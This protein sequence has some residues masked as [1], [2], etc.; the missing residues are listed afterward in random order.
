MYWKELTYGFKKYCTYLIITIFVA[1]FLNKF[2]VI[3]IDTQKDS[4]NVITINSDKEANEFMKNFLT[5]VKISHVSSIDTG[6]ADINGKTKAD[7][8]VYYIK[9]TLQVII[10]PTSTKSQ[11][12]DFIFSQFKT[13]TDYSLNL[14]DENRETQSENDRLKNIFNSFSF[15]LTFLCILIPYKMFIDEKK[16][17][18]ALL[19]SPIKNNSILSAKILT[20]SLLLAVACLF[21]LVAYDLSLNLI[22]V[23]FLFGMLYI[24]F[25]LLFGIFSDRKVISFV[26]Y[27]VLILITL[28]SM[29]MNNKMDYVSLITILNED[30]YK[31]L[32]VQGLLF[33]AMF[34]SLTYVF[35]VKLRRDRIE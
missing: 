12:I 30:I 31:L 20:T 7:A 32:G 18:K 14:M 27:P 5:D 26:L 17:L 15:V 8:F 35:K 25:G 34:Y 16:T 10:N 4:L 13:N 23:L 22:S 24:L 2:A 11:D 9:D 29:I 6:I 33:L 21:F 3:S 28:S 1:M 19:F